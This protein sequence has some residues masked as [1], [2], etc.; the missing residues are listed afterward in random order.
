MSLFY[1]L[2]P[3]PLVSQ[4]LVHF[5]QG[6]LPGLD[7]NIDERRELTELLAGFAG[8]RSDVFV[9]FREDLPSGESAQAALVDGCGAEE[10]DE[11]IEVRPGAAGDLMVRRWRVCLG[12][13]PHPGEERR[14]G[15]RPG[16]TA[17]E[18]VSET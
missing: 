1:L 4:R 13:S 6:L 2:P 14:T 18:P 11:V 8:Q 5:L 9:V 10:G 7:W 3:R 16:T 17:M 15:Q 12:T